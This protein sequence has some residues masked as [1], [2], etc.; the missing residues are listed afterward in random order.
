M[1]KQA[2]LYALNYLALAM[3]LQ[4]NWFDTYIYQ[5]CITKNV[6]STLLEHIFTRKYFQNS[7][8]TEA[9]ETFGLAIRNGSETTNTT[10]IKRTAVR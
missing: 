5:Q 9:R 7:Y 3:Y 2:L 8:R 1:Q 10:T 4:I 6:N